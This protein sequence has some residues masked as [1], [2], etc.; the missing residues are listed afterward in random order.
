MPRMNPSLTD[1]KSESSNLSTLRFNNDRLH[2][3][4]WMQKICDQVIRDMNNYGICVINNFLGLAQGEM[5]LSEVKSLYSIGI[6]HD[7]QL[8]SANRLSAPTQIIRGDKIF[9]VNGTEPQCANIGLL[10]Q[11]LDNILMQCN[12]MDRN[13]CF[14]NC[15]LS[16]RTR[17]MIA[18]YPGSGSHYVKHIDN[19][20]GDG[21]RVTS[22]YYLNKDWNVQVI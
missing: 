15:R 20:N 18:C 2:S 19:P 7:G 6:F 13:G 12:N 10:I 21:R 8:V 22:I 1:E 14:A 9:W 4:E 3:P 5:I 16:K 17:A 11:T